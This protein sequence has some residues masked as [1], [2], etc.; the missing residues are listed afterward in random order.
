MDNKSIKNMVVLKNIPSNIVE[1]AIVI[2]K[3]NKMAKRL[4]YIEKKSVF[5]NKR[6]EKSED[7]IIK[8]A[9]SVVANYIEKING[10]SITKVKFSK[11]YKMLRIYSIVITAVF[12]L[13]LVMN[14]LK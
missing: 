14:G 1:E 5:K 13:T 7:Y 8:E 6:I 3:T 12:L 10:N 2:F 4:E 9:E 11:N